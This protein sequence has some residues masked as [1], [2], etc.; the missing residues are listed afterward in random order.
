MNILPAVEMYSAHEMTATSER[1]LSLM[2][3]V[4]GTGI[5]IRLDAIFGATT[6]H[7]GMA[8]A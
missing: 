8:L 3:F 1:M 4:V 5:F 7:V 6:L 2:T